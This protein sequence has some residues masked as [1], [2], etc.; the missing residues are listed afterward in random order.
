MNTEHS[1]PS[2]SSPFTNG[3]PP[4]LPCGPGDVNADVLLPGD[5]DRVEL[6]A[7]MLEG[8]VRVR[9]RREFAF[10]SGR[11][12]GHPVSI[13][14]SGIGGPSTEIALVE[15]ALLGARRVIRIG[16]MSSLV[17]EIPVGS[18]YCV[19]DAIGRS[20]VSQL[21]TSSADRAYADPTLCN[22][23]YSSASIQGFEARVGKI[24]TT[25][26]YY[27]GQ[28]RAV[29]GDGRSIHA[30]GTNLGT[31]LKQG[32]LGVDMESEV[33]LCVGRSLGMRT[34]S[35]LGVHGNRATNEWLSDY[36][37]TQRNLLHIAA[38]ALLETS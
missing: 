29:S 21:Y 24:A 13:C 12:N 2:A 15:L 5:P 33:V 1:L 14:S 3:Y 7:D 9:R 34:A 23:L 4:H 6:L 32:A 35:L 19:E 10:V 30:K 27:R 31:F 38:R 20:G 18:Y 17:P 36:E 37:T 8:A 22:A 11:Y 26:S 16:G 25:D 28:D